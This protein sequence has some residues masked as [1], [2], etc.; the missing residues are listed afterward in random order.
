M[1]QQTL[2][3]P[4]PSL[5]IAGQ[6]LTSG[7]VTLWHLSVVALLWDVCVNEADREESYLC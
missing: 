6:G 5:L 1:V 2:L 4:V 3:L 7:A